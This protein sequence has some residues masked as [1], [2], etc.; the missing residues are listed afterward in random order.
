MSQII[1]RQHPS[2]QLGFDF[3]V[4]FFFFLST[5]GIGKKTSLYAMLCIDPSGT[6][7]IHQK[8]HSAQVRACNTHSAEEQNINIFKYL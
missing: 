1:S 6:H 8:H 2:K 5:W 3:L 7:L 4:F